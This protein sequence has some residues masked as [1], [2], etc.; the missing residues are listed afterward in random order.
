MD[1]A[2]KKRLEDAGWKVGDAR[3]FLELS[4]PE[5]EYVEIKAALAHQL[6]QSR[7]EL[8]LTQSEIAKRLKSSQSRVAKMEAGDSSVSLD[9]MIR[10]L[11]AL[12]A[13]RKDLAKAIRTSEAA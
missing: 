7:K 8:K 10:S 13:S 11:L 5:S 6:A 2:K 9:L 3:D 1:K 12:G 4:E